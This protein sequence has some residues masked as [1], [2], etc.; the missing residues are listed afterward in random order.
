MNPENRKVLAVG[1]HP[2]D[3]ESF[4]AGTLFLLRDLGYRIHIATMTLGDCGSKQHPAQEI[5]RI[6]RKETEAGCELLGASYHYVGFNDLAIFNDDLSNRRTAALLREVDPL[7]VMTHLAS[8]YMSDHETTSVLIRNACFSAPAP[9]YDTI[10]Y[11]AA[12]P[13]P[14][15]PFLY[16][17]EPMDGVNIFGERIAPHFYVD[18]SL[19][20][21]AR[22][23]MLGRHES[24]RQWLSSHHHGIDDYVEAARRRA[25][26]AGERA[27]RASGRTIAYA[28]G[29]R[30][31][32]GHA[33][34]PENILA[35]ILGDRVVPETAAR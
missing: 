33:Y 31:H 13:L 28:E 25:R 29:F 17:F 24:Q 19:T 18:I 7:L 26:D 15:I 16:Y 23:E 11:T 32:R 14:E 20:L 27:S 3:I 5:R 35:R 30:Q 12:G 4:C 1:A 9:N 34:P 2:D 21:E 10:S 6:R 8:D 22:L